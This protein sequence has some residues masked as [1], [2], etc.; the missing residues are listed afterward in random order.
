VHVVISERTQQRLDY[1]HS[2]SGKFSQ[3]FFEYLRCF[4][5]EQGVTDYLVGQPA[6]DAS[7]FDE[8]QVEARKFTRKLTFALSG[9][10]RR[11]G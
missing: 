5:E 10:L 7:E 1:V 3:Y 11:Q 4:T 8:Y 2:N 6:V 9:D